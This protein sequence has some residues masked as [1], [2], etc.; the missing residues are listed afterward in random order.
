[1]RSLAALLIGLLIAFPSFSNENGPQPPNKSGT[2]D[3]LERIL[4]RGLTVQTGTHY[5]N[6]NNGSLEEFRT[7]TSDNMLLMK[8][9]SPYEVK[10]K[11]SYNMWMNLLGTL[12]ATFWIR[13]Q[14]GSAYPGHP[15][16]RIGFSAF[17]R[18]D[19]NNAWSKEKVIEEEQFTSQSGNETITRKTVQ[20]D[21][22]RANRSSWHLMVRS[23]M[24]WGTDPSA[25][26]SFYGGAGLEAGVALGAET[27]IDHDRWIK[28]RYIDQHGETQ[29]SY[30]PELIDGSR[31]VVRNDPSLVGGVF[32]PLGMDLTLGG[33]DG[34]WSKL[35]L[36]SEIRPTAHVQKIPEIGMKDRW[37]LEL[38]HGIRYVWR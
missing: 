25:R 15:R 17:H 35:H 19:L 26:W 5:T 22:Y 4:I 20:N 1:M 34:F 38:S 23:S 29:E 28:R 36:F 7:L 16:L 18:T 13:D 14:N 3:T 2:G 11:N 37:D 8:D 30:P 9:L 27:S 24:I 33:G 31:K 32:L 12:R 6:T 10:G 21:V